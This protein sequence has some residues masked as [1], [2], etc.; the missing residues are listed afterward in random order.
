MPRA[1]P[2]AHAAAAFGTHSRI[3]RLAHSRE[4]TPMSQ[5]FPPRTEAAASAP[6]HPTPLAAAPRRL[7]ARTPWPM[8]LT[9]E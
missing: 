7:H 6:A 4:R 5:I 8:V 3:S 1:P 9:I 2:D